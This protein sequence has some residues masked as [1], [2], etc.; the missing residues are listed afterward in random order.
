MNVQQVV[1]ELESKPWI[2]QMMENPYA[3]K[4][5][6]YKVAHAWAHGKSAKGGAFSTD[7]DTL[8]SYDHVVGYTEAGTGR[9]IVKDCRYSVTTVKQLGAA[10]VAADEV[11]ACDCERSQA[12]YAK[13]HEYEF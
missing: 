12:K 13:R 10:K 9:K 11:I 2:D 6:R 5:N 8:W 1:A 7:G 4:Q 3:A